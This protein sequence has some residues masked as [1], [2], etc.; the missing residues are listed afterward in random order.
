M[1]LYGSGGNLAKKG[2]VLLIISD[3]PSRIS[4][5]ILLPIELNKNFD[6]GISISGLRKASFPFLRTKVS[7]SSLSGRKIKYTCLPF[8]NSGSE[9]SS[10]RQAA[11]PPAISPS[12]QNIILFVMRNIFSICST[13]A[14]VPKLAATFLM[15]NCAKAITSI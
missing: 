12:K 5:L 1:S 7:G 9:F 6:S 8:F 13:V 11:F 4:R 3:L 15:P 10:A 14:A 2:N